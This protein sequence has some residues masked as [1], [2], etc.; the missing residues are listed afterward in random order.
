VPARRV[1]AGGGRQGKCG[2]PWYFEGRRFGSGEFLKDQE[3]E[4]K[5]TI[6]ISKVRRRK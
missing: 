5:E 2:H 1:A 6:Y 4:T 3:R